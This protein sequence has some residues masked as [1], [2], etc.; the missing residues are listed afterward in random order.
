MK[1]LL[2]VLALLIAVGG[3]G[4]WLA[5]GANRGWTKNRVER[6]TID[7]VTGIEGVTYE[8]RFVPGLDFLG[9]AAI[10]TIALGG[11]SFVFRNKRST[12]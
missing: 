3:M 2:R 1:K 10:A 5:A 11:L 4:Y 6:K 12:I 8:N 7:E 9:G